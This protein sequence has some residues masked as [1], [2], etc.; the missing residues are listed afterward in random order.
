MSHGPTGVSQAEQ[1]RRLEEQEFKFRRGVDYVET[2]RVQLLTTFA[3]PPT[4]GSDDAAG[5]DL[6]ADLSLHPTGLSPISAGNSKVG[7]G[8]EPDKYILKLYPGERALVHTGVAMAVPAGHYGHIMPRS[9]LALKHGIAVMAG[10]ID[11]D[12]RGEVGVVLINHGGSPIEIKHGDRIA[13]LIIE[14][15]TPVMVKVKKN[16][17]VSSRGEAGFGSTGK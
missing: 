1:K 13:Q 9:G 3:T 4:Y 8:G 16:L 14:K 2:L 5:L 10:V 7:S 15:Y 12:Y 11:S 17:T 6:A